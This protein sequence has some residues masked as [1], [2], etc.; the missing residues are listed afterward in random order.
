MSGTG[1]HRM[2]R[3]NEHLVG[4]ECQDCGWV[5]YPEEKRVCKRCSA[6]PADFEAVRLAEC[7]TVQTF[8]VQERLPDEFETPQPLAIVDV[9][10]ADADGNPTGDGEPARVY[11]LLT[12]TS[13]DELS[14]GTTVE[15]R[16]RE[17]FTV[18]ERPIH[19]F[20]FAVPRSEKTDSIADA[21]EG[22]AGDD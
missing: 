11:G 16:F 14:V 15:A 17:L 1:Y 6:A 21:N 8:V 12:E 10:Q 19:S 3:Q 18:G 4:F 9:P 2:R 22:G 5:S 7:G 20:K 13:L